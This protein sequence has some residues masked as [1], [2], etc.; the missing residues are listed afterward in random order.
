VTEVREPA[1]LPGA[2]MDGSTPHAY[3]ATLEELTGLLLEDASLEDLLTQLLE[4][5]SRAVSTTA[6]VSV[7]VVGDDGRYLTAAATSADAHAV[8]AMQYEL[9]EGPCV[10]SLRTGR[11]HHLDDLDE[12][13]RWPGFR[14]RARDLGFGSVLSLP[15]LANGTPVGAL[16]LFAAEVGGLTEQDV[17][18][19]RRIA[20]PAATTLANARAY[21][22]AAR[23]S[24]QL[25]DALDG[26]SL[27]EQAKGVLMATQ[28]CGAD[29][30]FGLLRQ[31]SQRRNVKLVQVARQIVDNART[32]T[33][34]P[35][36]GSN[37]RSNGT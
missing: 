10:D 19:A 16:N 23:L 6:A 29:E 3:V 22:R 28:R 1:G 24:E 31:A 33:P 26:R 17:Q 37:G 35:G 15:L 14:E 7:T 12:E 9:D 32:E 34:R 8:D 5:T 20:A 36:A 2:L 18:L 21:R 25:Q 11:E 13:A 30:A 27:I 4:L